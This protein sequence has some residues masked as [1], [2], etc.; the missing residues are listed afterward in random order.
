VLFRKQQLYQIYR[1]LAEHRDEII[2]ALMADG[3]C[4]SEAQMADVDVTIREVKY[5]MDSVGNW[6]DGERKSLELV[7]AASLD[8]AEVYPEPKGT[9]L[10]IGT[11]NYPVNVLLVPLV[12]AIAAGNC[13][14]LK[15]SEVSANTS[16][17]L[18][19]L[20]PQYLNKDC[21]KIVYGAVEH[22]TGIWI[23]H[24]SLSPNESL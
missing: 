17:I 3:K 6:V 24:K 20:I 5:A 12:G 1:M 14:V 16:A 8:S 2:K 11:W 18:T 4:E 9:V 15:L 13:A 19:E 10:I 23:N 7:F 21:Y 22:S